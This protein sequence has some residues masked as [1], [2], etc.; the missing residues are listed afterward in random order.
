VEV[1]AKQKACEDD[2]EKAEPALVAAQ[3]ALNTLNKV[4][5]V[6]IYFYGEAMLAAGLRSRR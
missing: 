5:S 3:E 6:D 2:L 1:G 4:R